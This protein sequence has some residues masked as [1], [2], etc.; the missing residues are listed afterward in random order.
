MTQAHSSFGALLQI[1]DGATPAEAFTNVAEV[2]DGGGVSRTRTTQETTHHESPQAFREY[3]ATLADGGEPSF[4]LNWV[5]G[6]TTHA[7]LMTDFESAVAR[8]W[9]IVYAPGNNGSEVDEFTAIIT[10]LTHPT[11]VDGVDRCNIT[12]RTTG[13]VAQTTMS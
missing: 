7:K 9:R 3:I 4:E 1:G 13:P 2:R 6:A 8:N 5:F 11:P 10:N 12:L